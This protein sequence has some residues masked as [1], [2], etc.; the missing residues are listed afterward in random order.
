VMPVASQVPR[1]WWNLRFAPLFLINPQVAPK[2]LLVDR[3]K[4]RRGRKMIIK[5]FILAGCGW[6]TLPLDW[7]IR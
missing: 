6:V 2:T 3:T 5:R 4:P 1:S 7:Q